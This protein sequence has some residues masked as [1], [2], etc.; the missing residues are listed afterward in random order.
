M[1]NTFEDSFNAS[2]DSQFALSL[3]TKL[4]IHNLLFLFYKSFLESFSEPDTNDGD[5]VAGDDSQDLDKDSDFGSDTFDDVDNGILIEDDGSFPQFIDA[6][7]DLFESESEGSSS[8][9]FEGENKILQTIFLTRLQNPPARAL[10][11]FK[12]SRLCCKIM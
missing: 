10:D 4:V 3:F 7:D 5:Q 8:S 12:F 6:D 11:A 2:R 9:E 1:T